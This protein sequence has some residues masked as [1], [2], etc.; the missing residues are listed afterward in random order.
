[1]TMKKKI[2]H[3]VL[4]IVLAFFSRVR[5]LNLSLCFEGPASRVTSNCILTVWA[6]KEDYGPQKVSGH[7]ASLVGGLLP[8]QEDALGR[9]W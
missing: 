7:S 5:V 3:E 2:N 6:E 8:A 9:W 4:Q 1:M